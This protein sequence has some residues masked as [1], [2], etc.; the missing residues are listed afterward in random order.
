MLVYLLLNKFLGSQL[1]NPYE[2]YSI[3]VGILKSLLCSLV[4]YGL[5]RLLVRADRAEVAHTKIM[6]REAPTKREA[7]EVI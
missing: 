1:I 4:S 5:V 2:F 7:R 6:R 3:Y